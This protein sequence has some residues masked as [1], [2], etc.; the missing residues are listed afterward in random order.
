[1]NEYI[2]TL[3]EQQRT[4]FAQGATRDVSFRTEQLIRLKDAI[5]AHQEEIIAALATDLNKPAF[6]AYTNDTKRL[7]N[8]TATRGKKNKRSFYCRWFAPIT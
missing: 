1:M 6:E 5:I 4:F 7:I 3:I 8:Y 2:S